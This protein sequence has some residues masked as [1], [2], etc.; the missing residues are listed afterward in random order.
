MRTVKWLNVRP[1]MGVTEM[2][3]T[4]RD[5]ACEGAD[6]HCTTCWGLGYAEA[7]EEVAVDVEARPRPVLYCVRGMP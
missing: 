3:A 1:N 5:C 2:S 6:D 4:Y 7:R